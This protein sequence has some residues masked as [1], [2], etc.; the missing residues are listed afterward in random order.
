MSLL[1]KALGCAGVGVS[2]GRSVTEAV[3]DFLEAIAKVAYR[4]LLLHARMRDNLRSPHKLIQY[5]YTYVHT[6]AQRA[7]CSHSNSYIHTSIPKPKPK[8]KPK[9]NHQLQPKAS[10]LVSPKKNGFDGNAS[11]PIL[12]SA[13]SAAVLRVCVQTQPCPPPTLNRN[14]T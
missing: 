4:A 1:S 8:P 9:P 10:R 3:A 6:R 12:A 2:A 7:S 11:I 14:L 13:T 5:S